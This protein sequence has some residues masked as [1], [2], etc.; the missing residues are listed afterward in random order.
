M[1]R[2]LRYGSFRDVTALAEGFQI[3]GS[4]VGPSHA[5][6]HVVEFGNPVEVCGMLVHHDDIIHTDYQGAVV[7]PADCVK[8]LAG[9]VALVLRR[10]KVILDACRE[11]AFNFEKLK[12]AMARSKE[13]H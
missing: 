11:P 13:I 8:D 10:E 2:S 3:L 12:I 7:V 1:C 4:H 9:A 6:V 5:H